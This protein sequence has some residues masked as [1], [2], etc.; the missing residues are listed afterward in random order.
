V[1]AA[2]KPSRRALTHVGGPTDLGGDAELAAVLG[3]A[4]DVAAPTDAEDAAASDDAPS[5][6]VAKI[7]AF[8]SYPARL[9]PLTARR[10]V[11]G[12]SIPGDYVVDP[13]AGS[14][15]VI[16]EAALAGRNAWG[17]DVNPLAVRL[18]RRKAVAAK[19]AYLDALARAAESVSASARDR[20][21]ARAG[22]SRR[23]DQV[24]V[25]LFAPHVLLALDGLRVGIDAIEHKGVA[26]DLELVLSAILVKLSRRAS[27]TSE[28]AQD[29]RIA[30]DFPERLFARKAEELAIALAEIAPRL[31]ESPPARLDEE[32][33]TVLKKIPENSS[34]LVVTS[35]PY[36]GVYDYVAHHEARLRWLRLKGDRFASREIGASRSSQASTVEEAIARWEEELLRA[37]A[38]MERILVRGGRAVLVIADSALGR[39]PIRADEMIARLGRQAGLRPTA[40]A[41]QARPHFHG[42]TR[43]AFRDGERREHALLL[44]K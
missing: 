20:R 12:L 40:R 33:A 38:A 9:H 3:H 11:E 41:S 23:F 4:L 19:P 26:R 29:K 32:D 5:D 28:K 6:L 27:D 35:P 31:L 24:D 36:P 10:L 16:V 7:H 18:A 37:L 34:D 21:I 17:T 14:G 13:F 22:A 43:A 44:T 39:T 2:P 30:A 42:P 25:E 15:T 8:H 1:I